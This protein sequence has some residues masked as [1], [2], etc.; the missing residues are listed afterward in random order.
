MP[1]NNIPKA[2]KRLANA[3]NRRE[4]RKNSNAEIKTTRKPGISRGNSRN[5]RWKSLMEYVSLKKL[6]KVESTI[7]CAKPKTKTAAKKSRKSRGKLNILF[8]I[9]LIIMNLP[10]SFIGYTIN[11]LALKSRINYKGCD[12]QYEAMCLLIAD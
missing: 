11:N 6:L 10:N 1:I 4:Q 2:H 3:A 9:C 5:P 7:L 12:Q 8:L